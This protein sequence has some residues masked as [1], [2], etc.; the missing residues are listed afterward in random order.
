[1]DY[2]ELW[3]RFHGPKWSRKREL[4]AGGG[5]QYFID[6]RNY[7]N[8]WSF[9]QF[10]HDYHF[11]DATQEMISMNSK[12]FESIWILPPANEWVRFHSLSR[13][14][15]RM[16][17]SRSRLHNKWTFWTHETWGVSIISPSSFPRVFVSVFDPRLGSNFV[18]DLS[19]RDWHR[20]SSRVGSVDPFCNSVPPSSPLCL[21]Q[22]CTL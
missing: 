17:L 20:S 15:Q 16:A 22:D 7:F 21:E 11:I 14:I 9:E 19:G 12:C 6:V 13:Q 1:M 4:G 10:K 3:V 5:G 2:M 8:V 18:W